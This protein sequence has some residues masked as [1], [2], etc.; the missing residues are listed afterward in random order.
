MRIRGPIRRWV[1]AEAPALPTVCCA[2]CE[3]DIN[4][5]GCWLHGNED[6]TFC[7]YEDK[8]INTME[9]CVRC[10]YWVCFGCLVCP[11]TGLC[12]RH[13]IMRE[14]E[15][16]EYGESL[17]SDFAPSSPPLRP[18]SFAPPTPPPPPP[19]PVL[20]KVSLAAPLFCEEEDTEVDSGRMVI[21]IPRLKRA[22]NVEEEGESGRKRVRTPSFAFRES[23]Q[24]M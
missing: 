21:V 20:L 16:E 22:R 5:Q 2:S 18:R 12:N 13:Y 3:E 6:C 4:M 24:N 23:V 1:E 8:G 7:G 9:W 19:P 10:H 11:G 17:H 15:I 14:R